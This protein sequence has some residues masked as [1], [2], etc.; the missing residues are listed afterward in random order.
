MEINQYIYIL[1]YPSEELSVSYGLINDIIDS[2]K[3][4]HY[5]SIEAGSSGSPILSLKPFKVIGIHYG[6]SQNKN[7][8]YGTFIKY[9]IDEFNIY[10]KTEINIIYKTNLK[11]IDNIFGEKFLENNKNNIELIINGNKN[12]LINKYELKKGGNNIKLIIKN[13]IRN[14]EYMFYNCKSLNKIEELKYL[15][16]KDIYNFNWMFCGCSSLSDIKGLQN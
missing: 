1:H 2:K 11:G 9:A 5:C 16:I 10:H 12:S 8:N 3:I 13:K 7:L 4:S 14:L 15:D 6:S